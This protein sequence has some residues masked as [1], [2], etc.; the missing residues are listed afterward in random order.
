MFHNK[1]ILIGY[2]HVPTVSL[3]T[4]NLKNGP[5]MGQNGPILVYNLRKLSVLLNKVDA[6]TRIKIDLI[7]AKIKKSCRALSKSTKFH[8]LDA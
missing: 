7:R 3:I 2:F 4:T 6:N 5:T 1:K 8:T